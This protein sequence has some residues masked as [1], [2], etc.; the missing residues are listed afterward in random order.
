MPP[1][2]AVPPSEIDSGLASLTMLARFFGVP[3]SADQ[4]RHQ[5]AE[6]GKPFGEAEILLAAKHLGFKAATVDSEWSRLSQIAL[7]AVAVGRRVLHELRRGAAAVQSMIDS[8][9]WRA[10]LDRHGDLV[11]TEGCDRLLHCRGKRIAA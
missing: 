10:L 3:A 9:S 8:G 7:P 2:A 11:Q 6:S 5:F 4:L 1:H